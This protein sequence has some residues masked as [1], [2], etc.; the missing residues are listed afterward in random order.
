MSAQCT[1]P[2]RKWKHYKE[3]WYLELGQEDTFVQ[4]SLIS[5]YERVKSAGPAKLLCMSLYSVS[6]ECPLNWWPRQGTAISL[7]RLVFLFSPVYFE[8]RARDCHS[9]SPWY[10][11]EKKK[12]KKTSRRGDWSEVGGKTQ[13]ALSKSC[14][15]PNWVMQIVYVDWDRILRYFPDA[16]WGLEQGDIN[17]I[18]GRRWTT[19]TVPQLSGRP[20]FTQFE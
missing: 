10:Q 13:H 9:A 20:L 1:V 14:W 17:S 2:G 15:S 18:N 4:M 11:D 16:S 7:S 19:L 3:L 8:S 5:M 12:K 6:T